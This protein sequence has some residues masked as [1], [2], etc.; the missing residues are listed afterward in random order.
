MLEQDWFVGM[1]AISRVPLYTV[2]GISVAFALVFSLVDVVNYAIGFFQPQ[3]AK[4]LVESR[5]QVC[6]NT[7]TTFMEL[8]NQV[9]M[10]VAAAMVMGAIFGFTF[11]AL[12]VE[13]QNH[14]H[15]KL[16]LMREEHI[17]MPIGALLGGLVSFRSTQNCFSLDNTIGRVRQ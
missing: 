9:Q 4:P 14:Y 13:D 10:V 7:K 3:A 6:K 15:I 17:C 5:S 16:A 11:G 8:F 1:S 2:L 12:D